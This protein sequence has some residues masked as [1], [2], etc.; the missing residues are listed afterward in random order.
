MQ[1]NCHELLL[2]LNLGFLGKDIE[3]LLIHVLWL[4]IAIALI[5]IETF[6]KLSIL[7]T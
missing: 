5:L 3:Y 4:L 2:V 1:I 7:C 6:G